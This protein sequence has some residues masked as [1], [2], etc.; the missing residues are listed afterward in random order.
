MYSLNPVG[1]YMQTGPL[2]HALP[3]GR[4]AVAKRLK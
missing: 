1:D 4:T 2:S 3:V